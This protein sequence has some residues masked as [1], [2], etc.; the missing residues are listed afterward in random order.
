MTKLTNDFSEELLDNE[1]VEEKRFVMKKL[2]WYIRLCNLIYG[3]INL[4]LSVTFIYQVLSSDNP[5]TAESVIISL[6]LIFLFS[7]I[8]SYVVINS[9]SAYLYHDYPPEIISDSTDDTQ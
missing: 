2:P 1:L 3:I 5:I 6:L 7:F 9:I 8:A 4:L